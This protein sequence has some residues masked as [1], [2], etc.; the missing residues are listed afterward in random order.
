MQRGALTPSSRSS[1]TTVALSEGGCWALILST[2]AWFCVLWSRERG[3]ALQDPS[4]S[5]TPNTARLS[6]EF[7]TWI[8]SVET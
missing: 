8:R 5:S 3:K 6:P 2:S 1:V 7:A 4:S